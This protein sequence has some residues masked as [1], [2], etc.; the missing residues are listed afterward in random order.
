MQPKSINGKILMTSSRASRT[1]KV[2]SLL[3]LILKVFTLQLLR[4]FY[5]NA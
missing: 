4:N 1:S 3:N 5:E 2:I